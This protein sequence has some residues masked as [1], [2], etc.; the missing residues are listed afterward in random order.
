MIKVVV[1]VLRNSC[2][3]TYT[4]EGILYVDSSFKKKSSSC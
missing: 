3:N 4:I 2:Y 1:N